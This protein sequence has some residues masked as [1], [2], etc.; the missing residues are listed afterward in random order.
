MTPMTARHPQCHFDTRL[1]ALTLQIET[2]KDEI[3]TAFH[4]FSDRVV[5]RNSPHPFPFIHRY[6]VENVCV[7]DCMAQSIVCID[8]TSRDLRTL[9]PFFVRIAMGNEQSVR[10][11]PPA[12]GS[13]GS[14]GAKPIRSALTRS[15][16]VRSSTGMG[17]LTP[18]AAGGQQQQV[19]YLPTMRAH[20]GSLIMPTRP[21]GNEHHHGN[22]I[23]SP[24]WGWYINTTPPTPE[25]YHS[26]SSLKHS[27]RSDQSTTSVTSASTASEATH[28]E[29][30]AA[31]RGP[32]RVFQGL[33]AGANK[34]PMGWPSVPL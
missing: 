26:R 24:Q 17:D 1:R 28:L 23:E 31:T 30:S 2:S 4:L 29:N 21:V 27:E 14:L 18:S 13:D 19:R 22:G 25:M 8:N 3:V 34:P 16:S 20:Q 12:S 6:I 15:Q 11:E 7:G 32:N 10:H 33:K 9:F 5:V